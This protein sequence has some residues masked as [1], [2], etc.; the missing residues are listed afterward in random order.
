MSQQ[1]TSS[2]VTSIPSPT[3]SL[4]QS[5]TSS[6]R[7]G[8]ISLAIKE[9]AALYAAYM[10]YIKGGGLFVPTAKAYRIGDEV[11]LL[12]TLLDEPEKH[13]VVGQVVW[14]TLAGQPNRPQGIGIQ[15]SEKDGGTAIRNKIEG[16]IGGAL[17]STRPT[18]TL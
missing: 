4:D 8:V 11:F 15:F 13:K 6:L 16:I 10:P 3:P 1:P 12:L 7:P 9:K 17:K 2:P 14:I 18:H 5:Y